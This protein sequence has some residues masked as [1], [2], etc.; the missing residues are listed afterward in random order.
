MSLSMVIEQRVRDVLRAT[1]LDP[2]RDPQAVRELVQQVVGEVASE[3]VH[4]PVDVRGLMQ[5]VQDA[6]TGFGPLQRFFDDPQVEEVWI[7]E[8]GWVFIA[9][10][11]PFRIN[12]KLAL[13]EA[14]DYARTA[15]QFKVVDV[16]TGSQGSGLLG[17]ACQLSSSRRPTQRDAVGV[18]QLHDDLVARHR[19]T[20][21]Q[22]CR[23]AAQ[24][25]E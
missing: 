10:P 16:L 7:N 20:H 19:G 21:L 15:D 1:N 23:E 25:N 3:S 24:V 8:S 11:S 18:V 9:R 2:M 14:G 5:D 4:E 6:I 13:H 22:A 17:R 12:V